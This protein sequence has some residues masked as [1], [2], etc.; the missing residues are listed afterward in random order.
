[1]GSAAPFPSRARPLMSHDR[2]ATHGSPLL[3]GEGQG[4]VCDLFGHGPHLT[5][6][7]SFQEREPVAPQAN[8][9]AYE[10]GHP[11]YRPMDI[12]PNGNRA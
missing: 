3:E 1:V 7:L 12:A 2:D 6:T 4:E 9:S 11:V 5:P 8:A 10:T